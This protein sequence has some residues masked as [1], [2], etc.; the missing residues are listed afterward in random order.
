[1]FVVNGIILWMQTESLNIN[2]QVII[3]PFL[4]VCRGQQRIEPT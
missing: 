2:V 4:S 3:E 1:M